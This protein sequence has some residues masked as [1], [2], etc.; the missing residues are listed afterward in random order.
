MS[1]Y[2]ISDENFL[3]LE[4]RNNWKIPIKF[5]RSRILHNAIQLYFIKNFGAVSEEGNMGAGEKLLR[6]LE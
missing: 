5:M 3:Y 1:L 6:N 4:A 2:L